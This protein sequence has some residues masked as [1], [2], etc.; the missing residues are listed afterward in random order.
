MPYVLLQCFWS[1][2]QIFDTKLI[3]S[4]KSVFGNRFCWNKPNKCVK[5]VSV[6][7]QFYMLGTGYK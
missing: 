5:D 3:G 4:E 1:H 7:S 6:D 2:D